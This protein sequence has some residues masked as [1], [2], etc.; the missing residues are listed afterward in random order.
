MYG[1]YG[2]W[3]R[4]VTVAERKEK[5]AKQVAKALAYS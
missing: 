1:Y 3:A 2:R 5:A 4:Y